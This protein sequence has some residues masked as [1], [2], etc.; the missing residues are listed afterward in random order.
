MS[1]FFKNIEEMITMTQQKE[2]HK[3]L[4]KFKYSNFEIVN[5]IL[6]AHYTNGN[7]DLDMA[8]QIVSDRLS[9]QDG[10]EYPVMVYANDI[11]SITKEARDYFASEGNEG[12]LAIGA[13]M[14]S[15]FNR[16]IGNFYLKVSKPTVST[17]LFS[18]ED[19]AITWL[20][21][22]IQ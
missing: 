5:G 14:P 9:Y 13:I 4:G 16:M 21:K 11:I 8:K 1:M 15:T 7:I 18:T 19:E 10:Q 12:M 3:I 6:I 22:V 2:N 17:L 20:K